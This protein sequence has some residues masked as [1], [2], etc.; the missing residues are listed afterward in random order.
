MTA[1]PQSAPADAFAAIEKDAPAAASWH[2]LET[3][4]ALTT[5]RAGR[6]GLAGAEAAKRLRKLGANRIAPETREP[7]WRELV[8]PLTEPLIL[9]LMAVGVLSAVFGELRDGVAIFIIIGFVAAVQAGAHPL[10]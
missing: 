6:E 4:D 5:V 10:G 3:A 8:E 1:R 9:L 2:A 7:L